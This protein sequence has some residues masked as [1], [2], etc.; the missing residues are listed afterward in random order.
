MWKID[1]SNKIFHKKS[2]ILAHAWKWIQKICQKSIYASSEWE[3]LA[4]SVDN[5]LHIITVFK[6]YSNRSFFN[7]KI[8]Y[9]KFYI[10]YNN[11]K[12][13]ITNFL[14]IDV[15]PI[16]IAIIKFSELLFL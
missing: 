2:S 12:I 7:L 4:V 8:N 3:L 6:T 9:Y 5:K 16:K 1:I 10:F 15:N 11:L 13:L 14:L